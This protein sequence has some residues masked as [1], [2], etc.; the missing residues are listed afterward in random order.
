MKDKELQVVQK[1]KFIQKYQKQM[2]SLTFND[3][4]LFKT[5]VSKINAKDTLFKESYVVTYAELDKAGYTTRERYKEVNISLDNLSSKMLSF[6]SEKK[7]IR[8]GIIKNHYV[9]EKRS[10][11][12]KIGIYPEM[13]DFLLGIKE[14]FTKYPLS[15]LNNLINTYDILLFEYFSSI[16][17]L[18]QQKISLEKLRELLNVKEKYKQT[19]ELKK[20][21]LDKTIKRINEYTDIAVHYKD[22]KEK[23]KVTGFIF[24]VK[25]NKQFLV[26]DYIKEIKGTELNINGDIV[27]IKDIVEQEKEHNTLYRIEVQNAMG[28]SGFIQNDFTIQ[29]L[30][31]YIT[32]NQGSE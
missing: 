12:V 16:K 6:E 25:S 29:E 26:K 5:I 7:I 10:K 24:Y 3:L 4:L 30:K 19:L 21:L 13:A 9:Y 27:K 11:E 32:T 22:I 15:I 31:D 14:Q 28:L 2:K 1:N 20:E 17:K 8:C 23:N 18:G